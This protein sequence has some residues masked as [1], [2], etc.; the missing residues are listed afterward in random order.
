MLANLSGGRQNALATVA[1]DGVPANDLYVTRAS[2]TTRIQMAK[3]KQR[4]SVTASAATPKA[5]T[6]LPF[7][8]PVQCP[9]SA[10][11]LDLNNP[12]LQTG[13][14]INAATERQVIE[15]LA[16][17]AA[18]DE[19]VLSIC[20]NGYLNLE[21]LIVFGPKCGPY[22][23][24]EGNRRLSA[25]RLIL[26]PNLAL[27][28][29][30]KVPAQISKAV[31]KTLESVLV[32]RVQKHDDAREFIGFK[33]IN[34]PQRW[35]AYAKARYVTSWYKNSSGTLGIDEI[36]AK[37]GDNNNTLRSY[38][39]A[40]LIL[41]QASD[42][43]LWSME[44]RAA[45]R[46]R[47]A[48]SHFYTALGREQYQKFLGLTDG[49]SNKPPLK[50]IKRSFLGN[51]GEVL[52][53]MYGSKSA[54]RPSLV[55]SQNPDLKDLGLAIVDPRA[56]VALKNGATLDK[57]LDELKEPASAFHDA[58]VASKLRLDRA[59]GLMIRYTS[60]NEEIDALIEEIYEMADT[61]KT[62]NDKKRA[63]AN[64]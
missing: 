40:V 29:G 47:F 38:I 61:L 32:Y 54:D 62:M 6:D 13:D 55:K 34:G 15:F 24:L 45:S 35:D 3:V 48:F 44:D 42:A 8:T 59:I 19:L 16:D 7:R 10:L 52:A 27:D 28:L 51:L 33:H 31:L 37:M 5:A 9:I 60:G 57:A 58:L 11:K 39:Y 1:I 63:R 50:P 23:V 25:I 53:Y 4:T 41:E 12:R 20:T 30:I 18:L 56:R 2:H 46:G 26:D 17:I 49:W 43:G 36:A 22:V 14:D 64:A 21:P